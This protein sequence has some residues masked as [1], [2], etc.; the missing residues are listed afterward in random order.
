MILSKLVRPMV[1]AA[2]LVA[3]VMLTGASAQA[4]HFHGGHHHGGH[5]HSGF[6][7][8]G[9]YGGGLYGSGFGIARPYYGGFSRGFYGGGFYQ[10]Q[11][12]SF[13]AAPGRGL[14][15]GYSSGSFYP[16]WGGYRSC[17]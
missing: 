5:F 9:F 15:F 6:Y 10:P 3:G 8:G 4:Q 13:Y 2:G 14:G 1:L 12:M 17:W 7:G 11:G 16:A